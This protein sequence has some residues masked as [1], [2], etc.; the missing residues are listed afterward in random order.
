MN[1][2]ELYS[3][4]QAG[5]RYQLRQFKEQAPSV[6]PAKQI[7]ELIELVPTLFSE[8]YPSVIT[9]GNLSLTNIRINESTYEIT[10][11]VDWSLA[12]VLPFGM[13]L[14][15]LDLVTGF[16]GLRRWRTYWCKEDLL[17]FFWVEFFR[18]VDPARA[19]DAKNLKVRFHAEQAARIGAL[20]RYGF[21]KRVDGS[22]D[23]VVSVSRRDIARLRTWFGVE[24]K[25]LDA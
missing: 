12:K 10:N 22:S 5:I 25:S 17:N 1:P 24:G 7:D 16:M 3:I 8:K 4:R 2:K 11:I 9:N 14:D 20:L 23:G 6:L 13:D 15:V 19:V 18:Q 21:G